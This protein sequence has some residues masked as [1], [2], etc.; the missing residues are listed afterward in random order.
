[1]PDCC[2]RAI[3]RYITGSTKSAE[4]LRTMILEMPDRKF[5]GLF[6]HGVIIMKKNINILNQPKSQNPK[7]SVIVPVYNVKPEFIEQ[8]LNSLFNQTLK[9]IEIIVV[10]DCSSD[11]DTIKYLTRLQKDP[12]I[13]YIKLNQNSGLSCARNVG[14][15][16]ATG[17]YIGFLDSDD[18][19]SDDFYQKLYE[20]CLRYD[21]DI[22]CGILRLYENGKYTNLDKHPRMLAKKSRLKYK[23]I[24]N[25]SVA[26]KLFKKELFNNII[27]PRGRFYE[28]NVVLLKTFIK[29]KKIF[30]ENSVF[31]NYRANPCSII[32]NPIHQDKRVSDDIYILHS[33]YK[34]AKQQSKEDG[35]LIINTFL[36][37]LFLPHEYANNNDYYNEINRIFDKKYITKINYK[38]DKTYTLKHFIQN[39]IKHIFS[40]KGL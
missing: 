3:C 39:V 26:S 14:L 16:N 7:V 36:N 24:S 1:M 6:F 37:I 17:D 8:A 25:G 27:F 23:Y 33:I 38:H 4:N 13:K 11:T 18:W 40:N 2:G 5:N 21:C 19:V 22:S 29:S 15:K 12:R 20:N 10:N 9:E 35:D 31:Y 34:I 32:H 30:F 28:D